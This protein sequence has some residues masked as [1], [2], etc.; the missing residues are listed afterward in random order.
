MSDP[1][2]APSFDIEEIHD[3]ESL[4]AIAAEWSSLCDRCPWTTPFQRPEWLLPWC[5]HFDLDAPWAL[6]FRSGGSLVAFLPLYVYTVP[7]ETSPDAPVVL[8]RI[9]SV[10]GCGNSDYLD[11]IAEPECALAAAQACLACLAAGGDRWDICRLEDLR[12]GSP[13]LEVPAPPGW[14]EQC[15]PQSACPILEL[16]A[17]AR[18]L[19]EVLP[20]R[21][22]RNLRRLARLAAQEGGTRV[23]RADMVSCGRIFEALAELHGSRWEQR[24]LPGLLAGDADRGFHREVIEGFAARGTLALYSLSI[25]EQIVAVSYGFYEGRDLLFYLGGFDMRWAHCGPSILLRGA[26][27]EDAIRRGCERFD[28]LRGREPHKYAW[29]AEDRWSVCRTLLR[30]AP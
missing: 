25:G 21:Q 10:L 14:I 13:L 12:P 29:G 9:V 7:R 26:V 19:A 24:G 8:D 1:L 11:L 3:N 6:A 30:R 18:E 4:A 17:G 15:S 27:L 16:P 20:H 2:V 23:E 22:I 5:R 28:F